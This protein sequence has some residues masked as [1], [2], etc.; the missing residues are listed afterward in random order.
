[1]VKFRNNIKL[2]KK[3]DTKNVIKYILLIIINCY[4]YV[5]YIM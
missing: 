3:K 4:I 2:N 5:N 1:M